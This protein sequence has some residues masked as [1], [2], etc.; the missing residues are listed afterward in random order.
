MVYEVHLAGW[1]S[2]LFPAGREG[3]EIEQGD[4]G[5]LLLRLLGSLL[6][7]LGRLAWA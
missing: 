5:G 3:P 2:C 7:G 1:G 6:L 4:V